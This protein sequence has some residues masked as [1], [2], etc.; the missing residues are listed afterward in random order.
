MRQCVPYV[1]VDSG[2]K[3]R[4]QRLAWRGAGVSK[5]P[6][7][8]KK[9]RRKPWDRRKQPHIRAQMEVLKQRGLSGPP[10]SIAHMIFWDCGGDWQKAADWFEDPKVK[11]N[12]EGY[13]HIQAYMFEPANRALFEEVFEAE[14]RLYRHYSEGGE[15]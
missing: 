7:E 14:M 1:M 5:K 4:A 15:A 2:E 12:I 3:G 9:K 11:P 13:R 6:A 8:P 10:Q